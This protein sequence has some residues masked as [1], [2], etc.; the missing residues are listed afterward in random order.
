MTDEIRKKHEAQRSYVLETQGDAAYLNQSIKSCLTISEVDALFKALDEAP[1]REKRLER[2]IED[3][4]DTII[5]FEKSHAALK[6]E[7]ERLRGRLDIRYDYVDGVPVGPADDEIDRLNYRLAAAG[8]ELD[9][10]RKVVWLL[11][12]QYIYDG[13]P[14][15]LW[16][17]VAKAN[18]LDIAK[19]QKEM[20]K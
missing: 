15:V 20:G 14:W 3:Q 6:A 2:I 5:A 4:K 10:L 13:N 8:N 7:N 1:A 11:E 19:L 16:D 9:E 18:D 12:K 17:D